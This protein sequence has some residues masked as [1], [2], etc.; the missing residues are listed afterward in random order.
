MKRV[1]IRWSHPGI[2]PDQGWLTEVPVAGGKIPVVLYKDS[3]YR[4]CWRSIEG[5]GGYSLG[6]LGSR[7]RH[8]A[9]MKAMERIESYGSVA[10]ERA[11][12]IIPGWQH[13]AVIE[14]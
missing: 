8:E 10:L 6:C 14:P 5:R 4:Y 12:R 1:T 7:T 9:L 2:E 3:I 11:E 13:P